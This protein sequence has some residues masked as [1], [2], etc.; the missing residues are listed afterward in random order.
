MHY[1]PENQKKPCRITTLATELILHIIDYLPLESHFD[2]AITCKQ[3][4][5]CSSDI[6]KRHCDASAKYRVSS[7]L[8]PATVPTLLRSAFGYSDPIPAWH[9]LSFE[10]W[11][12]RKSWDEWKTFDFE[13]PLSEDTESE[14]LSW[15][16]LPGECEAYSQIPSSNEDIDQLL[17]RAPAEMERGYDGVLKAVLIANCPRLR[18]IKFVSRLRNMEV[19]DFHLLEIFGVKQDTSCMGWLC[20]FIQI[21]FAGTKGWLPG[22]AN[23]RSVSFGI[24][25]DTWMDTPPRYGLALASRES[26]YNRLVQLLHLPNIE[27]IYFN[28]PPYNV[29]HYNNSRELLESR[30]SSLRHI[31]LDSCDGLE[32]NFCSSLITAPRNLITASF[33][34]HDRSLSDPIF[35]VGRLYA[36]QGDTLERLMFY[37]D[38]KWIEICK[39][40]Q[41][42]F[43]GVLDKSLEYKVLKHVSY[44]LQNLELESL[45]TES[46]LD[47]N[48][49]E[50][51]GASLERVIVNHFPRSME[52]LTLRDELGGRLETH[53]TWDEYLSGSKGWGAKPAASLENA[54]INLIKDKE[55]KF[56]SLKAIFLEELERVRHPQ[57][58]KGPKTDALRFRRAIEVGAEYGVD[59]HTVTNRKAPLHHFD[60]PEP[61]DKYDLV[62]GPW[63]KRPED[64]VFN[65][66]TGRRE[67]PGCGKCG[68]CEVCL[69]SYSRELWETL[70][71]EEEAENKVK[72]RER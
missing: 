70:A 28:D 67:P 3:I 10:I 54:L 19:W 27:S 44:D 48:K 52:T 69:A 2:F 64:L 41:Y 47:D 58:G 24:P 55:E 62:T 33:R 68:N 31:F 13:K 39:V 57:N 63:G 5:K 25:S 26:S 60:Y 56:A 49:D 59:V 30:Y 32:F 16:F 1:Q 45:N 61:P 12:D 36:L 46:P 51:D 71:E 22:L 17:K 37:G 42:C 43:A 9:V 14:P 34:A 35:I 4:W 18:D 6:I 15:E 65:V 20:M 38:K 72:N 21:T 23:L 8:N 66:Y 50:P 29:C 40:F 53:G 11:Y 7:D